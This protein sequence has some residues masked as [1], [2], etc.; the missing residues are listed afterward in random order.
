MEDR[1]RQ[2]HEGRRVA[3]LAEPGDDEAADRA[4]PR[5]R[6]PGDARPEVEQPFPR[7]RP[8]R[9]TDVHRDRQLGDR[10][11][12][13]IARRQV[14]GRGDRRDVETRTERTLH[15]PQRQHDR[16]RVR[17]MEAEH[18]HHEQERR[19]HEE[20]PPADAVDESAR[21]RTC[22]HRRGEEHRHREPTHRA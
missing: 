21:Q 22:D 10:A 5:E 2:R 4:D 14:G 17:Q 11:R 9:E 8:D 7:P 13:P 16:D 1:Y 12:A 20:P 19:H 15:E 3:G 6:C 18:Q